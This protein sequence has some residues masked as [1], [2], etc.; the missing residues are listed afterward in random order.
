MFWDV[1]TLASHISHLFTDREEGHLDVEDLH[2]VAREIVRLE[3][4]Y[5]P[6]EFLKRFFSLDHESLLRVPL[7]ETLLRSTC[8]IDVY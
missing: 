6:F 4:V 2:D 1:I 3:G 8:G 7:R 5:D